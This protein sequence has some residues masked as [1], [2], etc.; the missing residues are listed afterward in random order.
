MKKKEMH[1]VSK[2]CFFRGFETDCAVHC[3][4]QC[5][6]P[7]NNKNVWILYVN[8]IQYIEQ[9]AWRVPLFYFQDRI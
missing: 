5:E 8:D 7:K 4:E 1:L 3:G 6:I 9:L 2:G